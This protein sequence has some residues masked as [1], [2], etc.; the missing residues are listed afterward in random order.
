MSQKGKQRCVPPA[1]VWASSLC[2]LIS[3]R[4]ECADR[5]NP[6]FSVGGTRRILLCLLIHYNEEET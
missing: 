1:G 3:V 6:G 2:L 4:C 5:V